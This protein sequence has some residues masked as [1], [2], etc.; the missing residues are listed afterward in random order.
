MKV[1]R[2]ERYSFGWTDPRSMLGK[3]KSPVFYHTREALIPL[4]CGDVEVATFHNDYVHGVTDE[5]S[6]N[7]T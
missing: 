2:N 6:E 7:R 1:R 5:S 3:S 4:E